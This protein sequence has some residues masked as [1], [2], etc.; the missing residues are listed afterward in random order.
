[1]WFFEGSAFKEWETIGSLLW[2]H[3]KRMYLI[4]H[5]NLLASLLIQLS[6]RLAPCREIITRLYLIHEKGTQQASIRA[7]TKC[8]HEMLFA[9]AQHPLYIFI[10]ALDECPNISGRPTPR[11]VLLGILEDLI[12]L[13]V[14]NLHI[15]VTS[16]PE[17]DIKDVLEPLAYSAVSIHDE[18]GQK[19]DIFDYVNTA[20]YS[21]RKM[22]KWRDA[23]KK[24]VVEVLSEKADGM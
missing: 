8:L 6:A 21:D 11:A 23:D 4:F 17:I 5:C 19:K 22:K 3:G 18:S 16:R 7:L 20:V 14:P 2:I 15:C 10:D 13:H 24:L 12:T 1:M 9:A